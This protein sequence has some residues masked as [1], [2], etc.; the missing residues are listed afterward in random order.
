[1]GYESVGHGI[2]A[3]GTVTAITHCPIGIDAVRTERDKSAPGVQPKM[4][5]LRRLYDGRKIIVGRDKLDPTKGVLPKVCW[6]SIRH[7]ML[8]LK[9]LH[10]H[11]CELSRSF[12]GAF[13]SGAAKWCWSRS[14]RRRQRTRCI[15]RPRFPSRSTTSMP[16]TAACITSLF[17][18]ITK[19]LS[20]T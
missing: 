7:K 16:P 8:R 2:E 10:L 19:R 17:I 18:T 3:N 15:W 11:S 4:E 12:S 13:P 6:L 20:G 5:A 1:M 14:Q 9:S